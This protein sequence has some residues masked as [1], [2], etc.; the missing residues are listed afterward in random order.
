[1]TRMVIGPI[2]LL[3]AIVSPD[4]RPA[5]PAQPRIAKYRPTSIITARAAASVRI[6]S[7][8]RFGQGRSTD[9]ALGAIRRSVRLADRDGAIHATELLEF[10]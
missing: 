5:M 9:E 7:G 6:V 2:L 8:A 1:M 3:A 10:Q 4:A